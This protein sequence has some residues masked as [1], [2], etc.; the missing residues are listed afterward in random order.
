MQTILQQYGNL[1][2]QRIVCVPQVTKCLG[3]TSKSYEDFQECRRSNDV[4]RE[5]I[6]IV[7]HSWGYF[8]ILR[9]K[10]IMK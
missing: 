5:R 8:R 7:V 2:S 4:I 10:F 6:S 9:F 1:N 3:D